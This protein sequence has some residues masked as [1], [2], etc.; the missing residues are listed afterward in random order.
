MRR[1]RPR[2]HRRVSGGSAAS[3]NQSLEVPIGQPR[4]RRAR[5][6]P[7]ASSTSTCRP[8]PPTATS[9]I[10][11]PVGYSIDGTP[12]MRDPRGMFGERLGVDMHLVTAASR[13]DAQPAGLRRA[14]AISRSPTASSPPYAAG[15]ALAGRRTRRDLGVTVIDMGGGTTSIAVFYEGHSCT[16]T[17]IPVG[18]EHVTS[19]IA[20]GLST[21]LA[22]AERMKTLDRPRRRQAQR[23]ARDHRRAAGRRGGSHASQPHPALDPGRHH[24][25]AHRGDLRAG[26]QPARGQRLRQ[27]G[28]RTRRAD[29]RR[30]PAR[31]RARSRRPRSSTSRSASAARC[32]SPAWPIRPAARPFRPLPACS[33][34]RSATT[35]PV[36]LDRRRW[37]RRRAELGGLA[38]GLGRTFRQYAVRGQAIP[39]GC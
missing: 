16:S 22:H 20:R 34:S 23:R 39:T 28:R 17:A 33:P 9:S 35:L 1:A 19:D 37:R 25:A 15:L 4:D 18:G 10:P 27:D 30:Q 11:M 32:G 8:R 14:A 31:R 36:R 5:R 12:G 6:A 24:P 38:V 2:G 3:H 7:R 13:R 21:P 26:A 29:R